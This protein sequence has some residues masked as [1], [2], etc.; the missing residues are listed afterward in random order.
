MTER[1]KAI[2]QLQKAHTAISAANESLQK[3][4]TRPSI[5]GAAATIEELIIDLFATVLQETR[6]DTE[7]ESGGEWFVIDQ[8]GMIFKRA[9]SRRE[10]EEWH[11]KFK[12]TMVKG[13]NV[14]SIVSAAEYNRRYNDKD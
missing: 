12:D 1:T 6:E 7:T 3:L 10:C 2:M 13:C 4:G 11:A 5:T 8:A 9:D 14:C